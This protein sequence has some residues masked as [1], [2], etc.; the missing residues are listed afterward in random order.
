MPRRFRWSRIF[1]NAFAGLAVFLVFGAATTVTHAQAPPPTLTGESFH[2][3]APTIT[4]IDC[5]P[6]D[7]RFTY[8]AT[9]NATGPYPGTFTETGAL[10]PGFRGLTA[11]F[12][13]DSPV[14]RVTG[15]KTGNIGATCGGA[16][17]GASCSGAAECEQAIAA[18]RLEVGYNTF[19]GGFASTDTYEATITT[20]V[21]PSPTTGCGE[22]RFIGPIVFPNAFEPGVRVRARLSDAYRANEKGRMQEGGLEA[23]RL[24]ESGAVHRVRQSSAVNV[25]TDHRARTPE[26]AAFRSDS[27]RASSFG[28]IASVS[29][30]STNRWPGD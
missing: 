27:V 4:S 22:A 25:P 7:I 12:T 5:G 17:G 21:E 9:G 2:Q 16:I 30:H 29:R 3:D 18:G 19:P 14:G 26:I 8:R 6:L 1:A 28:L 24:Q 13:I 10:T 20:S 15:T 11:S 23:P